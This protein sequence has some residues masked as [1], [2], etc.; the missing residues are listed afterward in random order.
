MKSKQLLCKIRK[1]VLIEVVG[2]S[3]N[4]RTHRQARRRFSISHFG[5]AQE[6]AYWRARALSLSPSSVLGGAQTGS[7]ASSS[8][9]GVQ[10]LLFARYG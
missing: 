3:M 1:I 7:A 4:T 5:F 2:Q 6:V 10:N 8:T 9:V